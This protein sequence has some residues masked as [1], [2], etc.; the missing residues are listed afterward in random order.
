VSIFIWLLL[1]LA[2]KPSRYNL[3]AFTLYQTIRGLLVCILSSFFIVLS[4]N[5]IEQEGVIVIVPELC[6]FTLVLAF[7]V[8]ASIK[9]QSSRY[10]LLKS[11][12]IIQPLW[13]IGLFFAV[14]FLWLISAGIGFSMYF[15]LGYI[16]LELKSYFILFVLG[17]WFALLYVAIFKARAKF[18]SKASFDDDNKYYQ[19][20]SI[21][22]ILVIIVFS[23]GITIAPLFLEYKLDTYEENPATSKPIILEKA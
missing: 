18:E 20:F 3:K 17:A 5:R 10:V 16:H 1:I 7:Y 12:F 13:M 15:A 21:Y 4:S 6:I 14:M 22:N 8:I 9:Q 2:D 23:L 11:L 19:S